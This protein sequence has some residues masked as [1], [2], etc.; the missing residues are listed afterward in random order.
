MASLI[1][2]KTKEYRAFVFVLHD[3]YGI[4]LLRCTRKKKKPDHWQIPGGRIDDHEFLRAG[5]FH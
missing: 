1:D 5:S 3:E 2:F 4:L